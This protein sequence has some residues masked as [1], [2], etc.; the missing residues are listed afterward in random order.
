M[1]NNQF[2][3]RISQCFI[4]NHYL[5]KKM[6]NI[7]HPVIYLSNKRNN[8]KI[9]EEILDQFSRSFQ[10][11]KESWLS[12]STAVVKSCKNTIDF[13]TREKRDETIASSL[14]DLQNGAGRIRPR[15]VKGSLSSRKKK[16]KN[17][18]RDRS[19]RA[20]KWHGDA[21]PSH[22]LLARGTP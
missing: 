9:D 21:V 11:R 5:L 13:G 20:N 19:A 7:R 12:H 15:R 2:S 14:N 6:Y 18:E 16:K 17:H 4:R 10:H 3:A 1:Q 22:L 8:R